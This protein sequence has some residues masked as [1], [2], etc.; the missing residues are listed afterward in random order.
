MQIEDDVFVRREG[1][2]PHWFRWQ[3]LPCTILSFEA[4]GTQA[5]CRMP[6][7]NIVSFYT[8]ELVTTWSGLDQ[9]ATLKAQG[10]T[11]LTLDRSSII[12]LDP[13]SLDGTEGPGG[14]ILRAR[15][16]HFYDISCHVCKHAVEKHWFELPTGT[17]HCSRQKANGTWCHATWSGAN[18]QHCVKCHRTFRSE[19]AANAHKARGQCVDPATRVK[20]GGEPYFAEPFINE[21]GTEIWRGAQRGNPVWKDRG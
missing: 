15:G 7:G 18:A 16:R 11:P 10:N 12:S 1:E 3:G 6:D 14:L 2:L 17:T 21:Y 13:S 5:A 9:G 4:D 20:K 8:W 19:A